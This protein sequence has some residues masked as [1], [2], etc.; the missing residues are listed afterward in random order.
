MSTPSEA[1]DRAWRVV[2]IA[3]SN[4]HKWDDWQ[5]VTYI[6]SPRER[7]GLHV[8]KRDAA[9]TTQTFETWDEAHKAGSIAAAKFGLGDE[10][11]IS[12]F[13]LALRLS[14]ILP[15]SADRAR[16]R[17]GEPH[18][19]FIAQKKCKQARGNQSWI[20]ALGAG[21]T[22]TR[23]YIRRLGRIADGQR[24]Y[25]NSFVSSYGLAIGVVQNLPNTPG[26]HIAGWCSL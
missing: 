14:D 16:I 10:S 7:D 11:D 1:P 19:Y 2:R 15:D 5:P 12:L 17:L 20:I 13:G 4:L 23:S 9:F 18:D 8:W 24:Q 21:F 3:P 25:F 22:D 6:R 26:R